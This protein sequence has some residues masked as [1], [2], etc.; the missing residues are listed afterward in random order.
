VYVCMYVHTCW[1]G[2]RNVDYMIIYYFCTPGI[3]F[4]MIGIPQTMIEC[5]EMVV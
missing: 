2:F 5:L 1:L 3:P 4:C